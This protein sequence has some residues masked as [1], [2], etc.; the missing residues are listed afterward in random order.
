MSI[1]R[2]QTP[3]PC[4]PVYGKGSA[5][6]SEFFAEKKKQGIK[7][8]VVVIPNIDNAYSK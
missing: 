8:V 6:I 5:N 2:A 4:F 7:L 3:F 1:G